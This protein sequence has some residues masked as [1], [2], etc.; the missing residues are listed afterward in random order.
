MN[1]CLARLS[2]TLTSGLVR[3]GYEL[4][5]PVCARV[6]SILGRHGAQKPIYPSPATDGEGANLM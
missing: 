5:G 3:V 4:E 1:Q 2:Q 6:G